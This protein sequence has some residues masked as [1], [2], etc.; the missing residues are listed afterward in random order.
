MTEVKSFLLGESRTLSAIHFLLT[1]CFFQEDSRML[2]VRR[3]HSPYRKHS[4]ISPQNAFHKEKVVRRKQNTFYKE[5]VPFRKHSISPCK[6]NS[7][8]RKESAFCKE[9]SSSMKHSAFTW[10]EVLYFSYSVRMQNKG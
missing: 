1:E 3:K 9:K 7:K 5:K 10:Q 2:S 4:T 8:S 6:N